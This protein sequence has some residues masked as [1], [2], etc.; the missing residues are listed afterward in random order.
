MNTEEFVERRLTRS[1]RQKNIANIWVT[2]A[3]QRQVTF[4]RKSLSTELDV[5]IDRRSGKIKGLKVIPKP[6][7]KATDIHK[8]WLSEFIMDAEMVEKYDQIR[9]ICALCGEKITDD[10]YI[11]VPNP[12]TPN[13]YTQCRFYHSKGE[14]NT[15]LN[16]I[17]SVRENWL[18][19]YSPVGNLLTD[20][21]EKI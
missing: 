9:M 21:V 13:D 14:C 2:P 6:L 17:A 19:N 5:D 16:Q 18:L 3:L 10:K 1:E 12:D 8:Q 7:E 4:H 15:R 20:F 11:V